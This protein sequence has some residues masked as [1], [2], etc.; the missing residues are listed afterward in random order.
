[1]KDEL[2]YSGALEINAKLDPILTAKDD[3]HLEESRGNGHAIAKLFYVR[4]LGRAQVE[5]LQL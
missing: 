1:M 5:R 3:L 4:V 2:K